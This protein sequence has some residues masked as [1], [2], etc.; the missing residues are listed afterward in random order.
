MTLKQ[1]IEHLNKIVEQHPEALEYTVVYAMDE[2]GNAYFPVG[3]KPS[4]GLY[5]EGGGFSGGEY[6]PE[7]AME[8]GVSPNAVCI[9]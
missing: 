7:Y 8:E 6:E 5:T 2:E 3:F 1:Y 9:N 4:V